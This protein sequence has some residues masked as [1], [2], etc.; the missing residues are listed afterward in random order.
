[1]YSRSTRDYIYIYQI[2]VLYNCLLH[3]NIDMV[4]PQV[5]QI[6]SQKR[7]HTQIFGNT[8]CN[9]RHFL[10]T[11]MQPSTQTVYKTLR[12]VNIPG[13]KINYTANEKIIYR[14]NTSPETDISTIVQESMLECIL[15]LN[16]E[17]LCRS[18][19]T[20]LFNIQKMNHDKNYIYKKNILLSNHIC[21]LSPL[22]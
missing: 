8:L 16:T 17:Q 3:V 9:H 19:F 20:L 21:R 5:C 22:L 1:M 4:S 10:E 6:S 11:E 7:Y 2:F 13:C 18:L 12:T 15:N 14:I